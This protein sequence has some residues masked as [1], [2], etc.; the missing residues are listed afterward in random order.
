MGEEYNEVLGKSEDQPH[1]DHD[2]EIIVNSK[3]VRMEEHT[4]TGEQ[5]KSCAIQQGVLI[6]A[7]FVL[8]E[9]SPSGKD[10]IIGDH[11]IVKLHK[12][13]RFTAIA[14]DDNS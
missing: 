6:N 10:K 7:N 12:G 9:E 1:G 8:Q 3:V 4:A 5:I 11:D 2:V 13:L 14:P